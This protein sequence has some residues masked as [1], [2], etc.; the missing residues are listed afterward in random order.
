M[1]RRRKP[2]LYAGLAVLLAAG[3]V[4]YHQIAHAPAG[5][6]AS[7]A[8]SQT[9]SPGLHNLKHI[10]VIL[11][12]NQ[13]IG[14]VIGNSDAP[15][16]NSLA[17]EY[18]LATGYYAT[19]H[20]SL[21]N[22]LDLT[23][24]SNGNITDD[25]SPPGGSCLLNSKNIA[26]EIESSGRTWREYAES[27]PAACWAAD[28]NEYATR[29][30][31]FVYYSDILND[32][33]RCKSH[34]VPFTQ[35]AADLSSSSTTPDFAFIT[36]NLC[37]DMHD[38]S[39]ATGDAWLKQTVP[40]ILSSPAFKTQNSLLVITW[41]EGDSSTNQIAAI[42][43]GPAVKN[44]FSSARLYSHYSLLRTVETAWGLAPLTSNDGSA[45]AMAEFFK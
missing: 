15:Y 22:Y 27:M 8:A 33:A 28:S 12:E 26:D 24:G 21:P 3:L 29:H 31:P 45:A 23:S 1:K 39:V 6:L 32:S 13:P 36:P 30:N 11:E 25:C 14:N 16:I 34:D 10:F 9:P 7:T 5:T 38:C 42:L 40:T 18:S 44:A 4:A 43:V 17:K 2:Y 41:D 19:N 37:N 20:P 35:F